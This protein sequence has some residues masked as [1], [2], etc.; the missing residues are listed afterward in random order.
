MVI[1][2]VAVAPE[3]VAFVIPAV[4]RKVVVPTLKSTTGLKVILTVREVELPTTLET[5]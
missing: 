2:D 3:V 5:P 4:I 1:V